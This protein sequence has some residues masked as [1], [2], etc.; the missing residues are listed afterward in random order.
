MNAHAKDLLRDAMAL[1]VDERAELAEEILASIDGESEASIEALW[2]TEIER[3]ARHAVAGDT[4][5]LP[6]ETLRDRALERIG[7]Q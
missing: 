5:G 4:N 1:P 7:R 6:W 3:R 2:G